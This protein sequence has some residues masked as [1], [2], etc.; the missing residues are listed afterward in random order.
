VD[1]SQVVNRDVD[2][3]VGTEM[4][5]RVLAMASEDQAVIALWRDLLSAD[6]KDVYLKPA[7]R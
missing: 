3:V 2:S 7:R 6:G 5:A 1:K 4:M